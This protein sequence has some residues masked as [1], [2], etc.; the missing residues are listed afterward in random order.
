M[1]RGKFTTSSGELMWE[2][3]S[4][5]DD[6]F[7]DFSGYYSTCAL[8]ESW[9][10]SEIDNEVC[11]ESTVSITSNSPFSLWLNDEHLYR[12]EEHF[13]GPPGT[14]SVSVQ[15]VAGR[16]RLLVRMQMAALR[17]T[18]HLFSL[19]LENF[20]AG[21]TPVHIPIAVDAAN[22][23]QLFEEFFQQLY[24]DRDLYSGPD[25]IVLR[26]PPGLKA[27]A[28]YAA[29]LQR[30]PNRIYAEAEGKEKDSGDR[31]FVESAA[32]PNG[33]YEVVMMPGPN[34]FYHQQ[35]R[36][37][38]TLPLVLLRTQYSRTPYATYAERRQEALRFAAY[39][40]G[41]FAEIAKMAAGWWKDLRLPAIEDAITRVD[42]REDGSNLLLLGLLGMLGRFGE[43]S[44]LPKTLLEPLADCIQGYRFALEEPGSDAMDFHASDQRLIFHTCQ[45]LAGERFPQQRFSNSGLTGTQQRDRG[46]EGLLTWLEE[47]ALYGFEAWDTPSSF[48]L[49]LIALSHLVDLAQDEDVWEMSSIVMDKIFLALALNSYQGVCG[50][51]RRHA[52][53]ASVKNGHLVPTAGISRLMWGMG[54]WNQQI[55]GPVSLACCHN[56]DLPPIIATIA[57]ES[58]QA[59]LW[60]S[61][62]HRGKA[63]DTWEVH[64]A[65]YKTAHYLLAAAQDYRPGETGQREHI[66]QATLGPDAIVFTNHPA[67][68]SESDAVTSGFWRGNRRLPRVAQWKNLLIA[69]Y[70]LLDD[71]RL[72]FTHAYFP[73]FAFDKYEL[74]GNWAFACKGDGYLALTASLPFHL[75]REGRNAFR[76]LRA[77]GNGAIWICQMGDVEE[78]GSFGNFCSQI[79]DAH[80]Q[81]SGH[82]VTYQHQESLITFGWDAPLTINDQ[83][84]SL[85]YERHYD[86]RHCVAEW[87]ATEM[88]AAFGEDALRI[89]FS[90]DG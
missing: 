42:R 87:P 26:W 12:Q 45:L 20:N 44:H 38:R 11:Q 43:S 64:K 14:N 61:E 84:Q 5:L 48:A 7:L 62:R 18:P 28:N 31:I 54:T 6:H 52:D 36:Y 56:Y 35:V 23:Y 49:H 13:H 22:R 21:P 74:T 46:R 85:R 68:M 80:V 67:C 4:C 10:Y 81:F 53:A 34:E 71:D 51:S 37:Q 73:T 1:Q 58:P 16:N 77:P 86:G 30:I 83:E 79:R 78:Y 89:A 3:Q 19:R 66:W 72:D 33:D 24:L 39:E 57:G 50:S 47:C 59:P 41:L 63:D 15:L 65:A 60:S 90:T 17:A 27:P 2:Y 9:A 76:E 29:R 70:Q 55:A 82:S 25:K 75:I 69:I 32:V 40:E 88:I 8:L